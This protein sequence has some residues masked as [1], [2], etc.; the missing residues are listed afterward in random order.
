MVA[1]SQVIPQLQ[2]GFWSVLS[3]AKTHLEANSRQCAALTA[4]TAVA[5]FGLYAAVGFCAA[6]LYYSCM[7]SVVNRLEPI[8]MDQ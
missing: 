1:L 5:G 4:V 3:R 6:P 7:I 8:L 2:A